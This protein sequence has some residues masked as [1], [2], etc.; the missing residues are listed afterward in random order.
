MFY[1]I[2]LVSLIIINLVSLTYTIIC[3]LY[4]LK[5]KYKITYD[6]YLYVNRSINIIYSIL[7]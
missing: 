5:E 1:K 7:F 3:L 2:I 4:A 6:N